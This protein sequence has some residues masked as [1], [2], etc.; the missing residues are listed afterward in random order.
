MTDKRKKVFVCVLNQGTISAGLESKLIDYMSALRNEY[1]FL[2]FTKYA[3]RPIASN[4]NEIVRDFLKSDCHY[5]V[6]VDDDN[7]PNQNFLKLLELNKDVI[8]VPTPGRN[9][10]GVFWMVYS[11]TKDYPKT[12]VLEAFPYEKRRGLQKIDAISTGAVIIARRVL[13]KLNKPFEDS[14]DKDG[15]IIHSDDISF[16]HKVKE[17]GFQE[18][19]HFDYS[20]SHY[21]TVDLLQMVAYANNMFDRGFIKGKEYAKKLVVKKVKLED[22]KKHG[23]NGNS[24]KKVS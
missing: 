7:P 10:K 15:V 14:F 5:L 6:M 22:L 16:A 9:N 23:I 12:V 20:C 19:A 11:F 24:L 8:G 18:W 21:K 17:K 2:F 4:R 1:N 3:G 13:V